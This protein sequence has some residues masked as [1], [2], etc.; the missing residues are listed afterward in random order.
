MTLAATG[1]RFWDLNIGCTYARAVLVASMGRI[2]P[3]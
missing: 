1:R 2:G 3:E